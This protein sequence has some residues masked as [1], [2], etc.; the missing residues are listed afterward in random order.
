MLITY[1]TE[2]FQSSTT[3][4]IYPACVSHISLFTGTDTVPLHPYP[5][6]I[7]CHLVHHYH[8]WHLPG[9]LS[10]RLESMGRILIYGMGA[11]PDSDCSSD[12]SGLDS[13][14]EDSAASYDFMEEGIFDSMMALHL[15]IGTTLCQT[16]PSTCG[17]T[18]GETKDNQAE[19]EHNEEQEGILMS[20]QHVLYKLP[21]LTDLIRSAAKTTIGQWYLKTTC[22]VASVFIQLFE[23]LSYV[24]VDDMINVRRVATLLRGFAVWCTVLQCFSHSL[25]GKVEGED[26]NMKKLC[27]CV[28]DTYLNEKWKGANEVYSL[29]DVQSHPNRNGLRQVRIPRKSD[30]EGY[31]E[32][33]KHSWVRP[34]KPADKF[35]NAL[36]T[37][38]TTSSLSPLYQLLDKRKNDIDNVIKSDEDVLR[39]VLWWY[40]ALGTD[41][42]HLPLTQKLTHGMMELRASLRS[43]PA[44]YDVTVQSRTLVLI[45][46]RAVCEKN[47]N[48]EKILTELVERIVDVEPVDLRTSYLSVDWVGEPGEGPGP[49]REFFGSYLPKTMFASGQNA[50]PMQEYDSVVHA[51]GGRPLFETTGNHEYFWPTSSVLSE[52]DRWLPCNT[53]AVQK[54]L[55]KI[56]AMKSISGPYERMEKYFDAKNRSALWCC[57]ESST[58]KTGAEGGGLSSA[59]MLGHGAHRNMWYECCGRLM[60]LSIMS[61]STVGL[62]LP[63][64]FF[65]VVQQIM[66]QIECSN[67]DGGNYLAPDT[68]LV[69]I[70]MYVTLLVHACCCVCCCCRV[71]VV[72]LS[73]RRDLSCLPATPNFLV[74][75]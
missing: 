22:N 27:A 29:V 60:G 8:R 12:D 14:D 40:G 56:P 44:T 6:P 65:H 66:N 48:G 38:C 47:E 17:S 33:R 23:M 11:A 69:E 37:T 75:V 72:L 61:R 67:S 64:L 16:L 46:N 41:G 35:F 4:I 31:M 73:C 28:Q 42:P 52:G 26:T 54:W 57:N 49:I 18:L 53:A 34:L 59:M 7:P 30:I 13:E 24:P 58:N 1:F 51:T 71:V 15:R 2:G 70:D 20:Y 36:L 43:I 74:R 21:L 9:P 5:T 62:R 39:T 63:V 55:K 50:P 10:A 25:Q 45:V 32:R 3:T 68:L 19:M